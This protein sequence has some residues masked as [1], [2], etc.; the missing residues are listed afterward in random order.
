M[1]KR[2]PKNFPPFFQPAL[3]HP[4]IAQLS[5]MASIEILHPPV[6]TP[7]GVEAPFV[8]KM[9]KCVSWHPKRAGIAAV[10]DGYGHTL[11]C[12]VKAE[13]TYAVLSVS[14][15]KPDFKRFIFM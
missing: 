10:V 13:R 8:G 4:V 14:L 15:L 7:S 6:T 1:R 9:L 2:D 12:D 5:K 3:S 11:I